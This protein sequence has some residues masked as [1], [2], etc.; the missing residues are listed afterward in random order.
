MKKH[1]SAII[2]SMNP[3]NKKL[4]ILNGQK[5]C[6]SFLKM[7]ELWLRH[8]GIKTRSFKLFC[9]YV[10]VSHKYLSCHYSHHNKL[11]LYTWPIVDVNQETQNKM[12]S[13]HFKIDVTI[14]A[15]TAQQLWTDQ[16]GN[17]NKIL[18]ISA[19]LWYE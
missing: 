2:F 1:F 13:F 7:V 18:I 19:K 10:C 12:H 9:R 14:W 5:I 6:W 15:R 11:L 4:K 8:V 17:K 3:T 16:F